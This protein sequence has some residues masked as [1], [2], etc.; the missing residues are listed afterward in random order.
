MVIQ[1]ILA[2]EETRPGASSN[3]GDH[4]QLNGSFVQYSFL[5]SRPFAEGQYHSAVTDC[6]FELRY[7]ERVFL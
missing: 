5:L 4:E 3:G 2:E 7:K 1:A 6:S